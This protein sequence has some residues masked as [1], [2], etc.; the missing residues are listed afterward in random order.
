M[1]G[2]RRSFLVCGR[3]GVPCFCVSYTRSCTSF[4]RSCTSYTCNWY[5]YT[6]ERYSFARER[7]S[8][9]CERYSFARER[10]SFA[11]ERYSFAR[12]C[13]SCT[14]GWAGLPC[15]RLASLGSGPLWVGLGGFFKASQRGA[16]GGWPP[17]GGWRSRPRSGGRF[18][19]H[20]GAC[21]LSAAFARVAHFVVHAHCDSLFA[22]GL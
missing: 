20:R 19:A 1:A 12:F 13:T 10:Y 15:E 16:G 22:L 6:C 14:C 18:A 9:A 8:F 5:S 3:S 11:R 4:A 7:Y 21:R 17:L 2:S